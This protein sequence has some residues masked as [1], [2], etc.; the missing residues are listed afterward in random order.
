MNVFD[1]VFYAIA[2]GA[3]YYF[4]RLGVEAANYEFVV[5][6]VVLGI[7]AIIYGFDAIIHCCRHPRL[8]FCLPEDIP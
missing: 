6:V 3:C 5:G 7:G 1:V 4:G 8:A 2:V